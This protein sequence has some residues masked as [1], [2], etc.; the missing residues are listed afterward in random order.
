M[1]ENRARVFIYTAM[2]NLG[3]GS[4]FFVCKT[5]IDHQVSARHEA[6][7][8]LMMICRHV[9]RVQRVQRLQRV[10]RVQRVQ[11]ENDVEYFPQLG[12]R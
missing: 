12:R 8:S 1:L 2:N 7:H 6:F 4:C 3:E 11:R 10:H 9:Q 5:K